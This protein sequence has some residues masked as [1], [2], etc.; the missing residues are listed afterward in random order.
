MRG[1]GYVYDSECNLYYLQSR[2]YDPQ[3]GRFINADA[4]ASTG[5][6]ILGN[7]MFAY[8]INN[9][10]CRIDESG[11]YSRKDA[12]E[13]AEEWYDGENEEYYYYSDGDCAN[14]VSQ[15]LRAGGVK[16][17]SGWYHKKH[18]KGWL[19]IAI[20]PLAWF[21]NKFKY[22]W[23]S[24]ETWRKANEQYCYF[25][26]PKN[27]YI[28]G[29]VIKISSALDIAVVAA[30]GEV[31][32]GDLLY[33]SSDGETAYHATMVSK[34]ENGMIYYTAHSR[35]R[36]DSPLSDTLGESTVLIVRIRDDA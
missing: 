18:K 13:Y 8:C 19:E 9:P 22:N 30:S 17:S 28:N 14:F 32:P 26:N 10:V 25:S 29:N 12:V 2:Y 7:N 23:N 16:D 35:S 33:F 34:V 15:C 27:G 4:F 5:Q 20:N 6:G 31:R 3:T 11:M 36:F 21:V 1:C 24:S